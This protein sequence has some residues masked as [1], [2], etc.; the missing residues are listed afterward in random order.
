MKDKVNLFNFDRLALENY[1]A[2]IG[3]ASYRAQ[4]LLKW[5][6]FEKQ[7][8]FSKMNN[9]SKTLRTKLH[10]L[11]HNTLP[12]VL[13]KQISSDGTE[14]WLLKLNDG[15]AI[16]TVFIPEP[17]RGT[18]C[19]SSQVGCALNCSFCSTGAMGFNRNLSTAEIIGQ[20]W[21]MAQE[22]KITN[23]VLMGMGEPLLNYDSVL[24][25]MNIMM[26][27]YAYGL[28]QYRVTLSTSGLVPALYR[29]SKESHCAL[30]VSLHAPNDELRNKLVPIN[31]KYPLAQLIEACHAFFADRPRRKVVFE[32]TM[33]NGVNDQKKHAEQL[34]VLLKNLPCKINLIPFNPFPRAAYTASDWDTI[35]AFQKKL[36]SNKIDVFIRK[37]R[38]QDI[39]AA[40]GQLVGEFTDRTSRSR[41]YRIAVVQPANMSLC[42]ST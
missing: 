2:S 30:A 29:L 12:T 37:T 10:E 1:F 26:D 4:Q 16:E 8:D 42:D 13:S 6:Y 7:L 3:E 18:L 21:L 27:H 32:Y 28:S 19:V 5:I 36:K 25:A 9:F 39:D 34:V 23:V 15:N 20:V 24:S 31:K 38:G 41:E 40:C 22:K 14:K 35:L 33:L 17:G 11:T